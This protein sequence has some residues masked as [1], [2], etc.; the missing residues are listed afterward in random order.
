VS[1]LASTLR[2][3]FAG[4]RVLLT[5]HTGFKGAWLTLWLE[6]LGAQVT[7]LAL[8]P[9]PDSLFARAE[10]ASSCQHHEVDVRR[11]EAV[12]SLVEAARPDVVLHLAAQAL[13]RRSY[14]EPLFTI[15]TNINGTAH[16]LEAVR[17]RRHRCAVV[18]VSSDKCYENREWVYGY[19][20][21]DAMGGHDPYSMSKGATELV[22]SSWRRSYFPP[23]KLKE[24]GVAVASARAGNVIGGGDWAA[25]RIVPDC[26]R[27]LM[28]GQPIGVRNPH[29]VRPWQ[30]VLEPLGGYLLLAARL[31]GVGT[32]A[33]QD[34]CE[35]WNFGPEAGAAQP[36][37][38]LATTLVKAWGSGAWVD[39]SDPTAHH[40]ASLLRLSIDKAHA[41]LGW[42]PR[43]GFEETVQRTVAW[44][45]EQVD[46]ASAARLR[47]LT[48]EQIA[49][50]ERA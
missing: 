6:R 19:R 35:P 5:G 11:F 33:P 43:W 12:K 7:G 44:Y 10:L 31:L 47:A 21:D 38:A 27:A 25:D 9:Q 4:K 30:H 8:A 37:S 26:I 17:Q 42:R 20:E 36:V 46:G 16:V 22:A 18:V 48:L 34:F 14:A 15:E 13:V 24:H 50:Y 49:D 40:E 45:R 29:A 41:K 1:D 3:A 39:Q 28:K 2:E 32:T 23:G